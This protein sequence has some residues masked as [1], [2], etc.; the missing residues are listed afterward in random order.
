MND[1]QKHEK[2]VLQR[3]E[4]AKFFMRKNK[5]SYSSAV[6]SIYGYM[7]Y[8][9]FTRVRNI[10][11]GK[12]IDEKFTD[13][14]ESFLMKS[15]EFKSDNHFSRFVDFASWYKKMGGRKLT[16]SEIVKLIDKF[17]NQ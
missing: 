3:L 17:N 14:L 6:D 7:T 15:L 9:E 13:D 12:I 8:K 1:K 11:S 4:R 2:K 16:E 10:L 5:I